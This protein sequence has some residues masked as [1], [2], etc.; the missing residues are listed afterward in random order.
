MSTRAIHSYAYLFTFGEIWSGEILRKNTVFHDE[1]DSIRYK[2]GQ[3]GEG[4]IRTLVLLLNKHDF[5]VPILTP[6]CPHF[7]YRNHRNINYFEPSIRKSHLL[8]ILEILE[9][10]LIP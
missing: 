1:Q 3:C 2:T 5:I 6:C 10:H 4:G 8:I 7:F 9:P